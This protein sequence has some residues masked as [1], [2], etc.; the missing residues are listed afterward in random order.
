MATL[1]SRIEVLEQAW[2]A[3]DRVLVDTIIVLVPAVDGHEDPTQPRAYYRVVSDLETGR[4][5]EG[6]RTEAGEWIESESPDEKPT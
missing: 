3:D 1:R 6:R 2:Q 5:R 4:R